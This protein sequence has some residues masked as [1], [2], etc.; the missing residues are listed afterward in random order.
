V[1]TFLINHGRTKIQATT[2]LKLKL[3]KNNERSD[4]LAAKFIDGISK[5]SLLFGLSLVLLSVYFLENIKQ[6]SIYTIDTIFRIYQS[7][8]FAS[9]FV[10]ILSVILICGSLLEIVSKGYREQLQTKIIN[11]LPQHK[12]FLQSKKGLEVTRRAR[13]QTLVFGIVLFLAWFFV[14]R[15]LI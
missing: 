13:L 15:F 7:M 10:F 9:G 11:E 14:L 3:Y 6:L 12:Q 2:W 8:D 5:F 4:Y 1:F